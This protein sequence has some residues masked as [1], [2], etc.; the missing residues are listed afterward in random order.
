M[1]SVEPHLDRQPG[2]ARS[3]LVV[4]LAFTSIAIACYD[5]VL[6]ALGL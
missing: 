3:A 1:R 4:L 2:A 6:L 5:L